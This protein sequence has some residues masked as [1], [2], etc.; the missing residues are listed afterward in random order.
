[1]VH[2]NVLMAF[3][4]LADSWNA[5]VD[6][7]GGEAKLSPTPIDVGLRMQAKGMNTCSVDVKALVG[8]LTAD[9]D[10][11]SYV[12]ANIFGL[13]TAWNALA[14]SMNGDVAGALRGCAE[15]LRQVFDGGQQ[16]AN[17]QR[18]ACELGDV[19]KRSELHPIHPAKEYESGYEIEHHKSSHGALIT[20]DARGIF[21]F[22][23]WICQHDDD[24]A[25]SEWLTKWWKEPSKTLVEGMTIV[26]AE[27][28]NFDTATALAIQSYGV[29]QGENEA[30]E[31]LIRWPLANQGDEIIC[32]DDY[33]WA[34]FRGAVLVDIIRVPGDSTHVVFK[35]ESW[36]SR[37]DDDVDDG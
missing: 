6:K 10:S 16:W 14:D 11:P 33:G 15:A 26:F 13:V 18:Q 17:S 19:M 9:V 28:F 32:G 8:A 2:K 31:L 36:R 3:L 27:P 20:N 4:D 35:V 7:L 24:G 22:H 25:L 21:Y 5:T 29:R 12:G 23:L 34:H 1:M 30:G 37:Y